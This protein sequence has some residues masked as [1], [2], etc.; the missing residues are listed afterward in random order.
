MN[1]CLIIGTL[2]GAHIEIGEEVG[3]DNMFIFGAKVEEVE[4][5]RTK[6]FNNIYNNF[7]QMVNTDPYSYA[8]DGLNSIFNKISGGMLG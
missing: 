3:F 1:G 4:N 7:I 2:D 6:V 5:L 8:G